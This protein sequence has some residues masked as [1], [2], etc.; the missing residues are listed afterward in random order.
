MS[1][2]PDANPHERG[3][4]REQRAADTAIPSAHAELAV[5]NA[6]LQE[7]SR[8][9][10]VERSRLAEIFRQA[11]VAIAVVR[12]RVARDLV[13]EL[14]NPR[15]EEVIPAG[16]S[17]LG[18][19]LGDVLPEMDEELLDVL[20]RVLDTGE[21]FVAHE[22]PV[23]LDRDGDGAPETYYFNFVYHPLAAADGT[24]TGVVGVGTEVTDSVR[25]RQVAEQLQHVAEV[26]RAAAEQARAE[27]DA[28]NRAKSEFLATMSHEIRTPINAAV[29]YTQLL[30]MGLAGPVTEQQREFLARLRS[31]SQH[32][33]GLVTEVLD[34]AKAEAGRM[35]VAREY[36]MTGDAVSSALALAM[37]TAE[38]KGVRVVD[39]GAGTRGV[40]Y[41]GDEARVRQI[42][43]NLLSNAIKFT[44]AGGTVTV[45]CDTVQQAPPD[46]RL[47]GG[48]PWAFIRVHDTGVGIAPDQ[49]A[50]VFEPFY[51]VDSG[52][53]R[54]AGGTGLGL[55]ISRRLARLMGG[56]L[57]VESARGAGS[58]FT[59]WLPAAAEVQGD[60]ESAA[61]R[62]A[63]ARREVGGFRVPSVFELGIQIRENSE[64]LVESYVARLRSDPL[65]AAVTRL[66]ERPDL[67]DHVVTFLVNLA[68]TLMIVGRSG[69]LESDSLA[70]SGDIHRTV[71]ELHGRQRHRLEWT[72]RQVARDYEI[73]G[74]ELE[75][76]VRRRAPDGSGDVQAGL[77]VV[78]QLIARARDASIRAYRHAAQG[79]GGL[80]S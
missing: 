50:A 1:H 22:Y 16:R 26:A 49:Q 29:G 2:T 69:G 31:S 51:Q 12:G 61:A 35:P 42:V 9:L 54:T 6:R 10:E 57:T 43:V 28:A 41:V 76:F 15:Y 46:A 56:D 38:A 7:L 70:D 53:T 11:P 75:A 33:M 63:R 21:P 67:E 45:R 5:A 52:T 3:F 59:L 62:G 44:P 55:T 19:R 27:A 66:L 30:E 25:A 39:E 48:G 14:V 80:S 71:S 64:A 40:P 17:P 20:Q 18:R 60:R 23:S 8:E 13:Y 24:V 4:R 47:V 34:L 74:E 79:V 32:L 68:Q 72:E 77:D 78:R 73:L 65:L 36:A 58:A 37:P